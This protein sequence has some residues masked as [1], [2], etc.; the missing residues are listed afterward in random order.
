MSTHTASIAELWQHP[1]V[2]D[3][4]TAGDDC[5]VSTNPATGEALRKRVRSG[6]GICLHALQ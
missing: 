5:I 2:V 4:S 3:P 1:L 6:L